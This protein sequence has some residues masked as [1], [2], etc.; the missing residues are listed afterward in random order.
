[1][2]FFLNMPN[3]IKVSQWRTQKDINT[4]QSVDKYL[5]V[6]KKSET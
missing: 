1:M 2:D 3:T 6:G 5:I 4:H